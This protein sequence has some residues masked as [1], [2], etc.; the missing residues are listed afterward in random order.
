MVITAKKPS[1]QLSDGPDAG[2]TRE[3]EL[4]LA[5]STRQGSLPILPGFFKEIIPALALWWAVMLGLFFALADYYLVIALVGTPTLV[6]LWPVGRSLGR[7]YLTYRP[8]PWVIGIVTMWM[9]PAT[10]FAIAETS[11]S[12]NVKSAVFFALPPVI[13]FLGVLVAAPWAQS[14]PPLRMFFRPDLLFGDGRTLV[15]GTLMLVLGMR[16]LFAGHPSD[17]AW[18]LP[19]W[20]WPSLA[21]GIAFGI[22]PIVLMRGMAK[23]VQRI[24]RLRDGL[25]SGYPSIAFREWLLLLLGLNF[26][27]AF[28]HIFIGRTVF[29][30]IGEAGAYP[31]TPQFWIGIGLMGAAALWML[32]V[33]GGFKKLIG[34]PFFFETFAQTLQKQLVFTL[35]WGVFFY[36][37]MSMLNSEGFGSIQPW[38]HQSKVGIGFLSAGIAVLTLGRAIAQHYQ[39]QGMLAHFVGVILPTQPDRGRE[40]M[41]ARIMEGMTRLPP[42]QQEAAWKTMYRSWDGIDPDE[43]SLMAWTTA[44]DLAALPALQRERLAESQARALAHLNSRIRIHAATDAKR[45]AS[46]LETGREVLTGDFAWP[47]DRCGG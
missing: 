23:L 10:G 14:R 46:R 44:N 32:F 27:F 28:H 16:Y 26:G 13:A 41:M 31:I 45:V 40:R 19:Q 9:I 34:E 43:R 17:V 4:A 38:D 11:W 6:M 24:M 12:F 37:F 5:I 25:F 42:D 18:A 22:I 1:S 36:G 8:L 21:F 29:S 39:R 15:G 20:S 3:G 33:K 35:A 2:S 7:R 30:T 47:S